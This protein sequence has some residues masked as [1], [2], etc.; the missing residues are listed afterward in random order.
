[1]L[2]TMVHDPTAFIIYSIFIHFDFVP[3]DKTLD[4]KFAMVEIGIFSSFF[5]LIIF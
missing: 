3:I 5:T 1:M 2:I 4:F